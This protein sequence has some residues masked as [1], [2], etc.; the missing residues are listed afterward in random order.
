MRLEADL[1]ERLASGG[2]KPLEFA[3][4]IGGA[5]VVAD[6]FER[7]GVENHVG[8]HRK[9]LDVGRWILR[10]HQ[11]LG[12]VLQA[13]EVVPVDAV[14]RQAELVPKREFV[15]AHLVPERL[16]VRRVATIG[17]D[18]KPGDENRL[19]VALAIGGSAP[20]VVEIIPHAVGGRFQGDD[21][22]GERQNRGADRSDG[23][24]GLVHARVGP[25][26]HLGEV[27]HGQ[28][29][30]ADVARMRRHRQR[31][32]AV[33]AMDAVERRRTRNFLKLRATLAA[34]ILLREVVD[35][36][37]EEVVDGGGGVGRLRA[38]CGVPERA[39]HQL[40]PHHVDLDKRGA[41]H[42][43]RLQH[44][45]TDGFAGDT[46]P[47]ERLEHAALRRVEGEID[48]GESGFVLDF[49]VGNRPKFKIVLETEAVER[50]GRHV[51]GETRVAEHRHREME[52]ACSDADIAPVAAAAAPGNRVVL[53]EELAVSAAA[54]LVF[55]AHERK[56]SVVSHKSVF[57][58]FFCDKDTVAGR[59]ARAYRAG[60]GFLRLI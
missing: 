59:G 43:P 14:E 35:C 16:G 41:A 15:V 34:V 47:L 26:S 60:N 10:H 52:D 17:I 28:V 1:L 20:L 21:G 3:D 55:S 50:F 38:H 54:S 32:Y 6:I 8:S 42:L 51:G 23:V 9:R 25:E 22:V 37:F 46:L 19:L 13:A 49:D 30:A 39:V 12:G 48:G 27:S 11:L 56:R 33:P 5:A 45:K 31:E 7:L 2:G 4:H 40:N 57:H 24:F 29:G 44:D 18:F 36:E 58:S 53:S